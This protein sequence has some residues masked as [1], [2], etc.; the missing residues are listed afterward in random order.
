MR[1]PRSSP[2]GN[3]P[4]TAARQHRAQPADR[5]NRL[6]SARCLAGL[7][8]SSSTG[9]GKEKCLDYL[10][11]SHGGCVQNALIQPRL[12]LYVTTVVSTAKLICTRGVLC[13]RGLLAVLKWGVHVTGSPR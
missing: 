6:L 9:A 7:A 4:A 10:R 5:S 1:S 12:I 11:T 8:P 3:P 13:R 2:P